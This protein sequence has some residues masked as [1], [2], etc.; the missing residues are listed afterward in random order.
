MNYRFQFTA[1]AEKYLRR[2]T[3]A[4]QESIL[5]LIEAIC[6]EPYDRRLSI[7]LHGPFAG[8]RRARVGNLRIVFSID[9]DRLLVIVTAIGPRGDVYKG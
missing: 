8:L 4:L 6:L 9:G 3:P 7:P 5:R 2:L 1:P